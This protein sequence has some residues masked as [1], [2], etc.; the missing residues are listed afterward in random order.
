MKIPMLIVIADDF[1]G[2]AEMAGIAYRYGLRV[3]VQLDF[4]G[5]DD[6]EVV[7]IDADTRSM[8]ES[9]AV[10]QLE[11][12]AGTLKK[13]TKPIRLFKK[14]D[15]AMRG[16]LL[17]EIKTLQKQ[18]DCKRVFLLPANPGRDRKIIRGKYFVNGI[19]L[20]KTVFAQDPGFPITSSIVTE[21][22]NAGK[23]HLQHSHIS[24]K[25]IVPASGII[26]GDIESRSDLKN[27]IQYSNANDLVCGAAECFEAY[28]EH[29]GYTADNKK[30]V[31]K[32]CKQLFF[33]LIINGSTVKNTAENDLI[34]KLSI[35]SVPLPGNWEQ[36]EFILGKNEENNWHK[37]V[38]NLLRHHHIV[39]VSV[40]HP[41]KEVKGVSE[42]FTGYFVAL[43]KYISNSIDLAKIHFCITGGATASA[44][45]RSIKITR[46]NVEEEVAHGVVTLGSDNSSGFFTVKPGSYPWTESFLKRLSTY[47]KEN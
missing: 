28:L 19:E 29:L 13:I 17:A 12:I 9:N 25:D 40:D 33:T 34:K 4:S 10:E 39:M 41:I 14:I 30:K 7:V 24:T 6:A 43:I 23:D 2:A 26:T 3:R 45:A 36:N 16:H 1:S 46:F 22:V 15:S 35:P 21:I 20:N 31:T 32:E 8:K 5:I 44:I 11:S 37:E 38:L 47:N 42:L 18:F 27:Y